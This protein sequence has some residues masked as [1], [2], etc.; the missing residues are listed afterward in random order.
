MQDWQQLNIYEQYDLYSSWMHENREAITAELREAYTQFKKHPL[1]LVQRQ[2]D[3]ASGVGVPLVIIGL[4]T[5]TE[6]FH[7]ALLIGFGILLWFHQKQTIDLACRH[8]FQFSGRIEILNNYVDRCKE[9]ALSSA[10]SV[11]ERNYINDFYEYCRQELQLKK[12]L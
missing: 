2:A 5:I 9:D 10:T 12:F 11:D 4:C 6:W 1:S 3:F 8:F 7:A